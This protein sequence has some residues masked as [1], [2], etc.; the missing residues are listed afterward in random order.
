MGNVIRVLDEQ[1]I[2][3]I[4]AGEVVERPVSVVKELVENAIDA[5]AT[6]IR[7][8]VEDGGKKAITVQDNGIGMSHD[9]AF[10]ALE[11]YAT[12]KLKT[13]KDLV[14]IATMGFRGEALA[15]I[16]SVSR[17]KLMTKDDTEE[18][19]TVLVVEGG[20][21]RQ[22]DRVAMNRGTSIEVRNLFFNVPVRRRFLKNPALEG[23]YIHEL[24]TRLVLAFPRITFLYSE[25]GRVKIDAAAAD[26][27][28]Q[29]MQTMFSRDL[30]ESLVEV[31][32]SI[33]DSRVSGYVARPP[34]SRSNM[35]SILTFV[36]SRSVKDRLVN[37][38]V[39]KAFS[40]LLD[41][42]RFPIAVLFLDIP[43]EEVDVNVHPQ[44]AELRFVKPRLVYDLVADGVHRA[45]TGA[46]FRTFGDGRDPW[47]SSSGSASIPRHVMGDMQHAPYHQ[48]DS[49][50]PRP[51]FVGSIAQ[52]VTSSLAQPDSSKAFSALGIVGRLPNSFLV[53]HSA[54]E[55]II[56]DHHAAHE[57]I[58]YE[59]LKRCAS[60]DARPEIQ[61]LLIPQLLTFSPVEARIL[62]SHLDL[63][64]NAGFLME[65]FGESE[66]LLRGVPTWFKASDAAELGQELIQTMMDTGLRGDPERFRDELLK[67]I[68][69]HASVKETDALELREINS[70]LA[71]LDSLES[72]PVCPH[73]RPFLVR[74]PFQEIRKKMGR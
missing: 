43:P 69:C 20:A 35:R 28:L 25:N 31:D 33:G 61:E 40:A 18:L 73:G 38:A 68:A 39:T 48:P 19:G 5:G 64:R 10:L 53:L 52:Q 70:L 63:L 6:T 41:K 55:L 30:R 3:R 24:V 34:F 14:G 72:P 26:S 1:V 23:G 49:L 65:E 27:V 9:D 45:L 74:I 47:I 15:S 4:A 46:P 22:S 56:M 12:S 58:L 44:K 59:S 17:L 60:E 29:R 50:E 8:A 2:N 62:A 11:R 42:G 57:R 32:H 21:L 13:E 67:R 7:I 54:T 16:A 37:G 71:Q 66:F 36:N 51:A